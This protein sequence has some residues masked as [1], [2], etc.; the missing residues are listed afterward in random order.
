M[1]EGRRISTRFAVGLALL[2]ALVRVQGAGAQCLSQQVSWW[3]GDGMAEDVAGPNEGTLRN[4]AGFGPGRTGLAFQL[5]GVDDHVEVPDSDSLDFNGRTQSFT[6]AA[7]VFRRST[8]APHVI[9][10]KTTTGPPFIG[11]RLAVVG[12]RVILRT[13]DSRDLKLNCGEGQGAVV[14]ANT[15]HHVAGVFSPG[16]SRVYLNGVLQAACDYPGDGQFQNSVRPKIGAFTSATGGF[17][18]GALD[19]VR[20]YNVALSDKDIEALAKPCP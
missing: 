15:W 6:V 17:L 8:G 1:K 20:I 12:D 18:A 10:D 9:Y 7:W 19:D 13:D 14:T 2:L 11:Y 4:G 3:S 16:K 5:D